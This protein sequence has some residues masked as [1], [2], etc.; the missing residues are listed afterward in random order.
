MKRLKK[1]FNISNLENRNGV[2]ILIS[3]IS[4]KIDFKTAIVR[5]HKENYYICIHTWLIHQ[6]NVTIINN[7]YLTELQNM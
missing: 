4:V 2:A 7:T 5:K 1:I 6:E 3:V